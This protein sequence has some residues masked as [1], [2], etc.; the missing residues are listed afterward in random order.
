MKRQ[1]GSREITFFTIFM[2]IMY[3]V[4]TEWRLQ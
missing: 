1:L 2:I 4:Y 3:I